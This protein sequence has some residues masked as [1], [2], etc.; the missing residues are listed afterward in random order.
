MF[1]E[2]QTID[3]LFGKEKR[4]KKSD[5]FTENIEKFKNK[6]KNEFLENISDPL[7]RFISKT[8]LGNITNNEEAY[9]AYNNIINREDVKKLFS[10]KKLNNKE[11]NIVFFL[12]DLEYILFGSYNIYK[13]R[14]RKKLKNLT[15]QQVEK[16]CQN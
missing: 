14:F 16:I 9:N 3:W 12:N 8:S 6:L 10:I 11:N 2:N 4:A 13:K 15:L 7:I 5:N 1:R